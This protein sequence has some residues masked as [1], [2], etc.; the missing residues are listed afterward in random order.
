MCQR[1]LE[2][3]K[4]FSRVCL[5][6]FPTTTNTK[7]PLVNVVRIVYSLF[8]E[9]P[10]IDS[11]KISKKQNRLVSLH[12]LPGTESSASIGKGPPESRTVRAIW[13]IWY[14]ENSNSLKIISQFP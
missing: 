10:Q 13:S 8:V 6:S 2:T 7:S 3:S 14:G 11:R 12:R 5:L 4:S 9:F 1:L